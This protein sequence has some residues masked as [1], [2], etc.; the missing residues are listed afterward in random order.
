MLPKV[1]ALVNA[2]KDEIYIK[3]PKQKAPV[4]S[5]PRTDVAV[6]LMER[7]K[8]NFSLHDIIIQMEKMCEGNSFMEN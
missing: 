2:F 1:F 5:S 3:D 4:T 7:L 8:G 6:K